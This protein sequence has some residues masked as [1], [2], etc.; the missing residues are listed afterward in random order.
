MNL[1]LTLQ[2]QPNKFTCLPTAFAIATGI[3]VDDLL[4]SIGHDGSDLVYGSPRGF[5]PQEII[6]VLFHRGWACVQFDKITC[7]SYPGGGTEREVDLKEVMKSP[8]VI[9]G[10][11][12]GQQHAAAWDG[13]RI[14]NPNGSIHGLV[15]V[16]IDVF[17]ATKRVDNESHFTI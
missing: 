16:D 7:M 11:F 17:F 3:P 4:Q 1:P 10:T 15:D 13:G 14:Y 2:C 6:E 8:G 5:H 12:N 9:C